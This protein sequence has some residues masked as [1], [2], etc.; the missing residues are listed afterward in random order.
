MRIKEAVG[1]P[2]L[3]LFGKS[4]VLW[5]FNRPVMQAIDGDQTIWY[6][7]FIALSLIV[8]AAFILK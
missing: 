3:C 5:L 4:V 2:L 1:I 6:I 8:C 7:A